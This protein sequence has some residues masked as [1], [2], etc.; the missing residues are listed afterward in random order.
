MSYFIAMEFLVDTNGLGVI[1]LLLVNPSGF[2]T[3]AASNISFYC[4]WYSYLPAVLYNFLMFSIHLCLH[5]SL[6]LNYWSIPVSTI[7]FSS[8]SECNN[9]LIITYFCSNIAFKTLLM[10]LIYH[11]VMHGHFSLPFGN[12]Y[13]IF[14]LESV[15]MI[16]MW[17]WWILYH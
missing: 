11:I 4:C 9:P 16:M 6:L 14:Q 5:K 15:W 12:I 1:R 8:C 3:S 13:I 10:L 2:E 17:L 7:C